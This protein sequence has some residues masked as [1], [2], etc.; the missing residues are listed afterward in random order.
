M[1]KIVPDPPF[2]PDASY[3]LE[4]TLIEATEHLL[5][6]LA[7]AQ[8]AVTT[9]PKSSATV[10][11]LSMMHEMEAVRALLESAIAQVQLK[12]PRQAHTLH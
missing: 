11:T 4:D 10:M 1:L 9:L 12:S 5:C 7:V 6:G 3:Y 2:V 8:Q